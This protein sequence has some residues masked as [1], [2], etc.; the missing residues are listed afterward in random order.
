[1]QQLL[2][3]G[4]ETGIIFYQGGIYEI[5]HYDDN[6]KMWLRPAKLLGDK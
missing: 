2:S 5:D 3:D 6:G 1:M 4:K